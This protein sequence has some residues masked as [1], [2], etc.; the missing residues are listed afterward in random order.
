[1]SKVIN[2]NVSVDGR[3]AG[4][5]RPTIFH[6]L[7]GDVTIG[8]GSGNET[9]IFAAVACPSEPDGTKKYA[10]TVCIKAS[11]NVQL[12]VRLR[13]GS[14][15]TTSDQFLYGWQTDIDGDENE[16]R[17]LPRFEFTP[18]AGDGFTLSAFTNQA[19]DVT[20][21]GGSTSSTWVLLEEIIEEDV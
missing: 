20:V 8:Q 19:A 5:V 7:S 6:E 2:A 13:R 9:I 3:I 4:P 15:G 18:D 17:I 10:A 11:A 14:T 1:M 16:V 12:I 21:E